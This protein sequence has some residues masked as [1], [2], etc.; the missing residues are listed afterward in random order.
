MP[1]KKKKPSDEVQLNVRRVRRDRRTAFR[2]LCIDAGTSM[3]QA[4]I[5][6]IDTCVTKGKVPKP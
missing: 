4:V 6:F 1:D 3:E 2:H 5:A